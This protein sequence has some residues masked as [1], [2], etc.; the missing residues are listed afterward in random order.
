M[1]EQFN[2]GNETTTAYHFTSGDPTRDI[3]F[4]LAKT[5]NFTNMFGT[6]GNSGDNTFVIASET[7]TNTNFEFRSGVGIAGGL[8]LAGGTLF[9]KIANDGQ[10][11]APIL[12]NA[13]TSNTLY[14]DANDGR[15]T[16][17][18]NNAAVGNF[19]ISK[20]ARVDSTYGNDST[21]AVGG[22]PYATIG[23]AINAV[24]AGMTVW[25]HPGIYTLDAGITI[26][27]GVCL[28]GQ[29][30][31]TTTIQ[32]LNVTQD[33]TLITMGENTRVEDLT[34]KLPS[35]EHRT[36][37]GIVFPG[38]TSV[39]AKL[40]TCVLT[41]DNKN[42]NSTGTS[43]VTG[44][45]SGGTGTL[46]A[47]TFSFNSVKGS[48]VNVYSNGAGKKRGILISNQN[49]MSTRDTN[50]YVAAPT[51][52]A[53]TG[54]YVGVETNDTT[55]PNLG[56]IQ[57]RTTT[58]G[59]VRP[60]TGNG[61]TASDILQTT[62]ATITDPI[63]LASAGIQIGPGVDLVTKS[64]GTKGFSSYIYPTTVYYGVRG[65]I[66]DGPAGGGYLWPGTLNVASGAGQS[67]NYPDNGTVPA[68]YRVQQPALI[69]G[70]SCGLNGIAGTGNTMTIL[71][72]VT[73][74][75]GTIADTAFTVAFGGNDTFK[76]F[77]N[78]SLTVNT[79]D[80]IHVQVSWTGGNQ[81]TAHDL[82]VQLDMF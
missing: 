56:S 22:S 62:P 60:A 57:L 34:L 25:V 10:L 46:N 72:R 7:G 68:Y 3:M 80:R 36:L 65:N 42:A 20:V 28:R 26:P 16:Y 39:T 27:D 29:N 75:G 32:M 23:A 49:Q 77:Y 63:Y 82:T 8:N 47:A 53:S 21:A 71:V 43:D 30:V 50:I 33:T 76:N 41:V 4:S 1:N 13:T 37:K 45:E 38:T 73:P 35:A 12:S 81:N 79:G 58:V 59:V 11:Y 78:A 15:L 24:T 66:A 40:R 18:A 48:T 74:N 31:Q 61:Y 70:I 14:Y 5:S 67:A 9:F 2:A 52:T 55:G 51:N 69:C 54:S 19:G 44:I 17:G 6:Y 64:A